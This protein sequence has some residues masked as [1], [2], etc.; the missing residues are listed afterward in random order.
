MDDVGT[1]NGSDLWR[2]LVSG[3]LAPAA[4]QPDGVAELRASLYK[5]SNDPAFLLYHVW[6][7]DPEIYQC[8]GFLLGRILPQHPKLRKFIAGLVN[9][10]ELFVRQRTA[11]V[12][13]GWPTRK[14]DQAERSLKRLC[15]DS[16]SLV[17]R[18]AIRSLIARSVTASDIAQFIQR[19][20][21]R[22]KKWSDDDDE[23]QYEAAM[24]L[25]ALSQRVPELRRLL[26][27]CLRDHDALPPLAMGLSIGSTDPDWVRSVVKRMVG[28]S[29]SAGVFAQFALGRVAPWSEAREILASSL[30]DEEL[31][32]RAGS[33]W[34]IGYAARSEAEAYRLLLTCMSSQ[35]FGTLWGLSLGMAEAAKDRMD[36]IDSL[37]ELRDRCLLGGTLT[38]RLAYPSGIAICR[39]ARHVP[40]RVCRFALDVCTGEMTIPYHLC[41][42][43]SGI[44]LYLKECAADVLATLD[45]NELYHSEIA[46]RLKGPRRKSTKDDRQ[47]TALRIRVIRKLRYKGSDL[48]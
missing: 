43:S 41:V 3:A 6:D 24:C 18:A 46:A 48:C 27:V 16:D 38:P 29:G 44:E 21:V 30:F 34:A 9:H 17:R 47:A 22:R 14:S 42:D 13:G 15:G 35:D 2:H 5:K 36:I 1:I 20:V 40:D 4:A 31:E 11:F 23:N 28:A 26:D 37:E 39:Q 10:D 33:A 32:V 19:F 45:Q 12:L 7:M 25:G 8:A